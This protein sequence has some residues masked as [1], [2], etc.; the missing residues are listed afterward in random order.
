MRIKSY[1]FVVLC[2]SRDKIF[3][4]SSTIVAQQRFTYDQSSSDTQSTWY[5]PLDYINKTRND[6]SSPIK[7]WLHSEAETV[8]HDVGAQNSWV[9]FNVNKTGWLHKYFLFS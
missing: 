5:I 1:T 9:V 4:L 7:T 2:V 8:M 6:W 3:L